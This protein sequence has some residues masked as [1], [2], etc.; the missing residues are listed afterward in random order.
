MIT[1]E[2][3]GRVM[4]LFQLDHILILFWVGIWIEMVLYSL[5]ISRGIE[6]FGKWLEWLETLPG[7]LLLILK[8]FLVEPIKKKLG[9]FNKLFFFKMECGKKVVE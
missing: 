3:N 1:G 5:G 7:R 8:E 4:Y 9:F 2:R 6:R